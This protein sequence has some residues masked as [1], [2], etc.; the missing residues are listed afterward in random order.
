MTVG[1]KLQ[2]I[3]DWKGLSQHDIAVM[4]GISRTM[5]SQYIRGVS[6]PTLEALRKLATALDI[7]V[8]MLI[9]NEPMAVKDID[10]TDSER[11]LIGQYRMLS[12]KARGCID[13]TLKAFSEIEQG[14][15]V[16]KP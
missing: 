10:L 1:D 15:N 9:N 13:I 12:G 14:K 6:E 11:Q 2:E 8:W 4:S 3:M 5:V 16:Q 7:S